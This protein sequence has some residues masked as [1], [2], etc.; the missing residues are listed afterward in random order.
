MTYLFFDI[1]GICMLWGIQNQLRVFFASTFGSKSPSAWCELLKSWNYWT[2][3]KFGSVV[4][5]TLGCGISIPTLRANF[6]GIV[7]VLCIQQCELITP[8]NGKGCMSKKKS[9]TWSVGCVF[10]SPQGLGGMED[11]MKT[12]ENVNT[13]MNILGK[14]RQD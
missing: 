9:F 14:T 1:F 4:F 10:H 7:N 8:K 6:E 12:H 13:W 2:H 5:L 3:T 11:L